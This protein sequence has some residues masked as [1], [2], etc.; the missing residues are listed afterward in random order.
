M[1]LIEAD[2]QLK[3][4]FYRMTKELSDSRNQLQQVCAELDQTS[5]IRNKLNEELKK[6][7]QQVFQFEQMK[8]IQEKKI[9]E[10]ESTIKVWC[11]AR[12]CSPI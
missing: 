2:L 3:L 10:S 1:R 11:C 5:S 12:M 4:C 9:S 6:S 7:K 8:L